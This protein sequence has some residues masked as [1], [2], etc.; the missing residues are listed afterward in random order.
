MQNRHLRVGESE[1]AMAPTKRE[2]LLAKIASAQDIP[3]LP[4]VVAPL[5]QYLQQ[6]LDT[7]QVNEV[8][9]LISQDESLTAQCL[10]FANSPMFGRWQ[11]VETVRGAVV[12]LGMRKMR[13]IATSCCLI[14]LTPKDCAI[15][16]TVFW[17]HALGVALAS[18]YFARAVGFPDADKAY[19][20]GLLHDF[21]M[22]MSFWVAPKEFAQAH[23]NAS[24]RHV[25]MYE[26][27][28]ELLGVTHCE[29]GQLL[30]EKWRMPADL[31]DVI[32]W[33][34]DIAR[35]PRNRG[36]V[37][38]VGIADLL[39]RVRMIGHGFPEDRQVDFQQEPAFQ[40][41]LAECPQMATLDWERFTFEMEDY[42]TEVRRLVALI[43]R[44]R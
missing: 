32:A 21:G 15:D 25:P 31:A 40:V 30:A 22:I 29:V 42:L 9:K 12:S 13:E 36:L 41:L 17:E 6:P 34:H 16:A 37:A 18:R 5:I 8:A 10:H 4:T 2:Q 19:L 27:E 3:S 24:S 35:A 43:Y 11:A 44:A 39:C 14:N 20:A 7:L 28:K 23:A 1:I 33:H 38:L 26:S